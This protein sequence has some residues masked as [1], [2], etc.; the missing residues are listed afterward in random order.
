MAVAEE[1][2]QDVGVALWELNVV[3]ADGE[4]PTAQFRR[5]NATVPRILTKWLEIYFQSLGIAVPFKVG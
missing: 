1:I 5:S 3:S 4:D 2:L